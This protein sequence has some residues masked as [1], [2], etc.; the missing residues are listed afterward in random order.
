MKMGMWGKMGREGGR[1]WE[2]GDGLEEVG[3][4]VE[5]MS[6]EGGEEV[7]GVAEGVGEVGEGDG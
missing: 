5:E 4:E 1:G 2:G 6:G 7:V 3:M